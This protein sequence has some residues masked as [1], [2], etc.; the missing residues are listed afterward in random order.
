MLSKQ[1]IPMDLL[2]A[3]G[4]SLKGIAMFMA[5]IDH[6][7]MGFTKVEENLNYTINNLLKIFPKY[8]DDIAA[9]GYAKD[10]EM[11]A[12]IAYANR[13]GNGDVASGD[14]YKYRGRGYIQL[15]GRD[16]YSKCGKYMGLNLLDNPALLCQ[17]INAMMSAVWFFEYNN[18][19]NDLNITRVTKKINGGLIGISERQKLF[20]AYKTLIL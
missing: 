6:E 3:K 4:L 17:P 10:K 1:A 19:L 8:F 5:Q 11:I 20:Q 2:K 9:I 15:T 13:M 12:N 16:N 18:I 14:G 7:S